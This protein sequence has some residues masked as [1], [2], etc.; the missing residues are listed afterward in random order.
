MFVIAGSAGLSHGSTAV[1]RRRAEA[2][3]RPGDGQWVCGTAKEESGDGGAVSTRQVA[4]LRCDGVE[5]A[6]QRG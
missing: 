1:Q 4:V 5:R 3:M 2:G 6:E